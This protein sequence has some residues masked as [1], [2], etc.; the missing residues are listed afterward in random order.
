MNYNQTIHWLFERLPMYQRQGKAAYKANLDNIINFCAYLGNPQDQFKSIHVAGTNGKGSTSHM[1][2]SILQ[3]AGYKT[4]LHTSPH[5]KDFR[6]RTRINGTM[7]EETFVIE[8]IEKH[9]AFIENLSV[10]FFEVTVAM[11]FEYFATQQ[12]DMAIIETGLGGRLDSTNIIHPE[13]SIITNIGLDHTAILGDDIPAIAKEKAGIM[14]E[15]T[16]VVIGESTIQTKPIFLAFAKNKHAPIYFAEEMTLPTYTTDLKGIYQAKNA[17]TAQS[18]ARVLKNKGW[19]ISET[20]IQDGLNHVVANTG[21]RGRWEV[22]QSK[23]FIVADT[24]HN[25]EG[26]KQII[27]QIKSTPYNQ[28]HLVLGFVNDKDVS[29]ILKMFP[30]D[31]IYYLSEPKVPRKLS[32]E[33]LKILTPPD[34]IVHYFDNIEN[35][36]SQAKKVAR[37]DDF[38]Y[39]GGS[40]FVVAEVI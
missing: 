37:A 3:E 26:I 20:H 35:A 39:I 31:A 38:I 5:L 34:L 40:T 16:A 9:K 36:L 6:E 10:S 28:L 11:A 22:L 7:M 32:V 15:H 30:K 29:S 14:K 25:A 21:L 13:V 19:E 1:I 2:A 33:D 12:V 18:T 8:F 23:P 17:I 4:G 24:A 27:Q